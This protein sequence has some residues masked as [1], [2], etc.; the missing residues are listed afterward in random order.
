MAMGTVTI[1]RAEYDRL[2]EAAAELEDLRA[3]D[4]AIARLEAG[5]DDLIPAEY[6][7]RILAGEHPLRIYR[8]LRSY[9]QQQLADASGVN[10]VQIADIEGRRKNGSI[11]TMKRLAA[12][13][14]LAIDDLV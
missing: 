9:T 5:E 3:Y 14:N 1:D 6:V 7:A 12:A 11:E 10:R 13:L 8:E 4:R 2:I